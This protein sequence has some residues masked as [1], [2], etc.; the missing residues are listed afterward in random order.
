MTRSMPEA[1]ELSGSQ[2]HPEASLAATV[3]LAG[4][5]PGFA[6]LDALLATLE[7]NDQ[8]TP[9]DDADAEQSPPQA[10]APAEHRTAAGTETN[11]DAPGA[12]LVL[13]GE[14]A[15]AGVA[16]VN[17]DVLRALRSQKAV[18]SDNELSATRRWANLLLLTLSPLVACAYL[19][20]C[21]DD[22][23][24]V[25]SSAIAPNFAIGSLPATTPWIAAGAISLL[26]F[27]AGWRSLQRRR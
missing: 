12:A 8:V 17:Y 14:P 21:G 9:L 10:L 27:L 11:L 23:A 1:P 20:W 19:I 22:V 26:L 4:L 24:E 3:E 7:E 16:R 15:E 25:I 13:P 5:S 6:K 18:V 2:D